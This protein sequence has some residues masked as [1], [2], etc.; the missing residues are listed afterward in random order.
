MTWYQNLYDYVVWN[1]II[2][3][4]VFSIK[5]FNVNTMKVDM[6]TMTALQMK[7]SGLLCEASQKYNIKQFDFTKKLEVLGQLFCDKIN[8]YLDITQIQFTVK[9]LCKYGLCIFG[10]ENC[11]FY[12]QLRLAKE[13]PTSMN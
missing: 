1:L 3:A 4:P 13:P 2:V 7:A 11:S 9:K 5:K 6:C 12:C 10:F 8:L